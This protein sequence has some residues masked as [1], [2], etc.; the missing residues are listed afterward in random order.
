MQNLPRLVRVGVPALLVVG[1]GAFALWKLVL[2]VESPDEVSTDAALEQLAQDLEDDS[3]DAGAEAEATTTSTPSA[4]LSSSTTEAAAPVDAA[5]DGVVGTW[6]VDD[7][8]GDFSFENASG[9][10]AGFRVEKTLFV[11]GG[12]TAVGRSGSVTGSITI[13]AGELTGGEIVVDTTQIDSDQG[14]RVSAIKRVLQTGDFPTATFVVTEAVALDTDALDAGATVSTE[15][16][17]DLTIAGVTNPITI[18]IEATVPEPGLGLVIGSAPLVWAD[19]GVETPTS[20]AGT[21]ADDGILEFQL[22]VR[23]G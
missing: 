10:F 12:Q 7:E 2:E 16:T 14:G 18:A 3:E 6:V 13:A 23:L 20:S 1:I 9:S 22:I 5:V 8:F 17:G 4:D 15:V 11:G 21:V 19:H